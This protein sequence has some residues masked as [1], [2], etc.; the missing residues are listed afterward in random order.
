MMFNTKGKPK[1]F[2]Y[3]RFSIDVNQ[4]EVDAIEKK[5]NEFLEMIDAEMVEQYWEV[6]ERDSTKIHDIIKQ[7]SKNNW[8]LLT[9][10]L[11]TLHKYKTGA[12]SI[13]REGDEV[14]VP[15]F[16]IDGQTVM[17]VLMSGL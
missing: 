5:M 13:I 6:T 14:G 15:V 16:F 10:D 17:E 3:A 2:M 8:N 11:K 4:E 1:V 9:Y 7:C 12:L